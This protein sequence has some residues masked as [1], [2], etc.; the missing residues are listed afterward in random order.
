MSTLNSTNM[1]ISRPTSRVLAPPGG[2]SSINIFGGGGDDAPA[3]K[4]TKPAFNPSFEPS[5]PAAVEVRVY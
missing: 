3:T 5:K 4:T 1:T 2:G